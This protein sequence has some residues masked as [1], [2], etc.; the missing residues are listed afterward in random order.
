MTGPEHYLVTPAGFQQDMRCDDCRAGKLGD[1]FTL[2]IGDGVGQLELACGACGG[3]PDQLVEMDYVNFSMAP[4]PVTVAEW[5]DCD[6]PGG[7]H[8]DAIGDHGWG[9]VITP[10]T[11]AS[12]KEK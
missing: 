7:T 9:I 6:D 5:A 10:W 1:R 12:D 3:L 8:I 11:G 4:I 2:A